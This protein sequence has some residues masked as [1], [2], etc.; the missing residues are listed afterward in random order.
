MDVDDAAKVLKELGHPHRL[1]VFKRLVKAGFCGLPVGS[2]TEDLGIPH[3][4]MTH[5]ISHLVGA[6]L[7][8]QNRRG[9]VLQ[10]VPQYQR[11]WDVI[12]FLQEECC[13]EEPVEAGEACWKS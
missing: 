3:S 6:G 2:L 11:L 9:R 7:I 8:T 5:H 4:S 12:S 1:R 10:C 13:V